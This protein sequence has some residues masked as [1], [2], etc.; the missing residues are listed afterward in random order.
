MYQ[1]VHLYGVRST[2]R[3]ALHLCVLQLISGGTVYDYVVCMQDVSISCES[4][5][6]GHFQPPS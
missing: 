1:A 6:L 5:V 2:F 3:Q 4:I